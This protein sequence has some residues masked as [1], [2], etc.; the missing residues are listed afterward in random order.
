MLCTCSASEAPGNA[1]KGAPSA[2]LAAVLTA[3][4]PAAAAVSA[5]VF[6]HSV[7]NGVVVHRMIPILRA[8]G[9]MADQCRAAWRKLLQTDGLQRIALLAA[10]VVRV[11]TCYMSMSK[12][13]FAAPLDLVCV[14]LSCG[15][16]CFNVTDSVYAIRH[17]KV[18]LPDAADGQR[19]VFVIGRPLYAA[20]AAL[21]ACG[22]RLTQ[23]ITQQ[24]GMFNSCLL[25]H[26]VIYGCLVQ[27]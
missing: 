7:G 2:S 6:V 18:H 23:L 1:S 5:A 21:S 3:L 22:R 19:R 15:M 24:L 13:F 4:I 20:S 12:G 16:V 14:H 25:S 17:V 26:T 10:G 27:L 11:R 9:G 8:F